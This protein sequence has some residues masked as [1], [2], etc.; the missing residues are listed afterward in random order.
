M[1]TSTVIKVRIIEGWDYSI[2]AIFLVFMLLII[3]CY[4]ITITTIIIVLFR[5]LLDHLVWLGALNHANLAKVAQ[6]VGPH[7]MVLVDVGAL[8][9]RH[10]DK[11]FRQQCAI[12]S[13]DTS[14][15]W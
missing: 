6:K 14:D 12:I 2:V 5:S 9:L 8:D 11:V 10:R 7:H 15:L 13:A 1:V 4:I 3:I